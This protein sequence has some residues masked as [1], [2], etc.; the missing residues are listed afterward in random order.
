MP[1]PFPGMDPN[2]ESPRWFHGFHNNLITY[3]E[4]QLQPLLPDPYYAQSGQR[5]W[6]DVSQRL[7]EPDVNL[8]RA[9]PVSEP[10]HRAS[11][12]GGVAIAEPEVE[13]EDDSCQPVLIT[14]EEIV[15][16]E[17]TEPFLEIRGRWSGQDRLVATIEIVSPSNK[18][19]GDQ[20]FDTYRAK[21]RD[22]LASQ[23]HLIEIDLL[24]GGTH[25]TAV[26]GDIAREKAGP[27]DYLV[28]VDRFDV[29]K[30]YFVYP[31]RLPERL[32]ILRIPL[33][34][35]DPSVRLDLQTAFNRAYDAGPYRKRIFYGEDLIEPPLQIEQATW[36]KGVLA[37][38]S[39]G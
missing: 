23:V 4:E 36:A 30:A 29:P 3:L 18:T 9:G 17:H 32:P 12:H 6:L 2:L 39:A 34:P 25:I 37:A 38:M 16:D 5:V 26:P 27:F 10:L 33:L 1:S 19:P 15:H 31:I 7:V 14:I 22:V 35:G 21:Q 20:A 13:T 28:S 11:I 24:R 8:M